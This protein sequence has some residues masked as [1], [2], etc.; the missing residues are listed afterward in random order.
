MSCL[1]D[2]RETNETEILTG[3]VF[4]IHF[5]RVQAD[6]RRLK[7]LGDWYA[8]RERRKSPESLTRGERR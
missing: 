5:E 7:E 4:E 8:N 3:E 6:T 1:M 2:D